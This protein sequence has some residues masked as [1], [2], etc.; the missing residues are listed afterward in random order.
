MGAQAP[1][2]LV[3]FAASRVVPPAP[4]LDTAFLEAVFYED[5]EEGQGCIPNGI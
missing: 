1:P 5:E 3:A 4:E 2:P